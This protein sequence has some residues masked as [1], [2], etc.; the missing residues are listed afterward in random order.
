MKS[1]EKVILFCPN[2]MCLTLCFLLLVCNLR[3]TNAVLGQNAPGLELIKTV[4]FD[5]YKSKSNYL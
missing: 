1:G 2:V 4:F 5:N 3:T